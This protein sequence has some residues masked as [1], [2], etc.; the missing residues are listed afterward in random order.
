MSRIDTITFTCPSCNKEHDITYW[1]S[2]NS[3]LNP[4]ET[5]KLLDGTLFETTCP[6]CGNKTG[7]SYPVL[8]HDQH[9]AAM[10]Y[11]LP[12]ASASDIE[13]TIALFNQQQG[14]KDREYKFR[15]VKNQN[16]LREKAIIFRHHLD[17]G[18]LEII[19]IIYLIQMQ[20]KYPGA[21]I[22]EAYYLRNENDEHVLCFIADD[23][24]QYSA[25]VDEGLYNEVG[26]DYNDAIKQAS[27]SCYEINREW[28]QMLL[29]DE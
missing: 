8:Y 25:I 5:E 19:K 7:V 24:T 2:L 3:A 15:I 4:A 1:Q 20:K 6:H 18:V 23:G 22:L 9:N 26:S 12:S 13:K 10:V 27:Q 28:A 14:L 29:F 11:L 16:E 21:E 17:D